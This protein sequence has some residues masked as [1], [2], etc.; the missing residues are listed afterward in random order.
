MLCCGHQ[1][2]I[3]S[4]YLRARRDFKG[5]KFQYSH[6]IDKETDTEKSEDFSKS[7]RK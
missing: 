5:Y 1:A 3:E 6:F 7:N 2:A 4:Q